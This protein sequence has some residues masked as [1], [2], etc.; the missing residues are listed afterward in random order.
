MKNDIIKIPLE[1]NP[2]IFMEVTPGHFTTG[3]I[4]TNYYL[5]VSNMKANA[6]IAKD[7]A[8]ELAIPYFSSTLVD[9]IICMENTK[10]IGAFLAEELS[11]EGAMAMNSGGELHVITPKSTTDRKLIF[12]DNE[13]DWV[14][15]KNILLLTAMISSGQTLSNALECISYYDGIITGISSLFLASDAELNEKIHTL[16]TSD[17][18]PGYKASDSDRCGMCMAGEKLDACISG[19]GYKKI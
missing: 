7:I 14:Q 18:I 11:Q 13:V 9:T 6:L 3:N 15:N 19:D 4:H 12:Y 1:K 2:L 5:D 17:D 8:K 16:F 10:V